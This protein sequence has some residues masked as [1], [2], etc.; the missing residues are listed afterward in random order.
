[1]LFASG[2]V[3]PYVPT[4]ELHLI[5]NLCQSFFNSGSHFQ[6]TSNAYRQK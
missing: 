5:S 4:K 1:L 3:T 2:Y 6:T